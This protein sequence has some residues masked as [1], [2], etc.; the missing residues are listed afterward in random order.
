MKNQIDFIN[1][2]EIQAN[3]EL[4][5]DLLYGIG[6]AY[7]LELFFKKLKGR[8]NGWV[9]YTLSRSERQFD[10]IN[11]GKWYAARQDAT[12]TVN[13]VAMVEISPRLSF[14]TSFVLNSGNAVTFPSGKY[15]IDNGSVWY[16]AERNGYR[17]PIY[18][19][20]DMG[21]TLNSKKES[22]LNSSWS[23]GLYNVY[24]HKN[25]YLIDF[26]ENKENP[27]QTEAYQIALFGIVP[28]ITWNFNF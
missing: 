1:G 15:T 28:S 13:L 4:E 2:A 3:P 20:L 5:A 10:Q 14:S 19:R 22:K 6:R 24:D 17:M 9:S 7:G 26:R 25:A 18:H 21:L 23:F 27:K 12:H 11:N 16:Y 8:F